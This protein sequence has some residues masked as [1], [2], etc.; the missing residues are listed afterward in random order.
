VYLASLSHPAGKDRRTDVADEIE[1]ALAA[2]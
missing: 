1:R 2:P